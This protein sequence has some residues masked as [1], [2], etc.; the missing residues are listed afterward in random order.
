MEKRGAG[1]KNVRN[2]G[3]TSEV[4]LFSCSALVKGSLTRDLLAIRFFHRFLHSPEYPIEAFS[5]F[6][7]ILRIYSNVTVNQQCQ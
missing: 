4:A 2:L 5:N 3:K 6:Y 1:R 7:K